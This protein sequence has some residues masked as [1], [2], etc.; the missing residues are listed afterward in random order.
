MTRF[1]PTGF[2]A[3][4]TSTCGENG[5]ADLEE[6]VKLRYA[7]AYGARIEHFHDR[8]IGFRDEDGAVT[9]VIG[10][11]P[12][13]S[14]CHL[15]IE[16]YVDAPIESVIS[17]ALG[18]QVARESVAEVGNLIS[19]HGGLGR[20]LLAA[21]IRWLDGQEISWAV[22]AATRRVRLLVRRMGLECN[23]LGEADGSRLGASKA[24]WGSYYDDSP[25]LVAV[26]VPRALEAVEAVAGPPGGRVEEAQ[27][28]E[29]LARRAS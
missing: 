15:F 7:R 8:L 24:L 23:D 28:K 19:E 22:F 5:R 3:S 11:T 26:H 17:R 9:G 6:A 16:N 1:E 25:R 18:W 13:R 20:Y 14:A 10:C 4:F 29:G 2:G 27:A 12:A 21:M